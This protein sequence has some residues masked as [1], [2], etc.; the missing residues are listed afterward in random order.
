MST[1]ADTRQQRRIQV[2][3]NGQ[4]VRREVDVRLTVADFVRHELGLTGTHLG[5][6]H[7]VCGACTILVNGRAMRGCLTLAVQLDGTEIQTVEDLA[8]GDTLHPLQAA[9]RDHHGLQCGYCTAGI[10]MTLVDFLAENPAP[11]EL[12]L[13]TALSGNLCRCTGYQNI[14]AAAMEGAARLRSEEDSG[15]GVPR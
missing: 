5:C 10:L 12:E 3:V 8:T 4:S 14:I 11:D 1:D 9:F 2:T 6:E 13:K 15:D 7:G